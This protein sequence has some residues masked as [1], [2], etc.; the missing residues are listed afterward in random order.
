MKWSHETLHLYPSLHFRRMGARE[1]MTWSGGG[2]SDYDA[3]WRMGTR[4]VMTLSGGGW[5][6]YD[7]DWRMGVG[8]HD[9]ITS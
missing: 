7:V 8:H 3:D 4:E 9:V 6:V 5:S 1:V 2:W